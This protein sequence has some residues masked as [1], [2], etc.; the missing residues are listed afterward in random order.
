MAATVPRSDDSPLPV[1][2]R[3]PVDS[4]K[5]TYGRVL[6]VGG[7]RGMTGAAG[8]SGMAA[9]RAGAGLVQV[10]VAKS[11]QAI[12]AAYEP[13]YM[14][15]GLSE[16]IEGRLD[17][18]AIGELTPHL[19]HITTLACGPGLALT[20]GTEAVALSLYEKFERPAVFDADAL[21]AL[22]RHPQRLASHAGPRVLT[23]HPGEFARLTGRSIAEVQSARE[24][25]AGE[26]ARKHRVV[27]LLKG[28]RTCITD[29]ERVAINTTGN[30]GMATGGTGDVLTGVVAALLAQGLAPYD[31]ARLGA[32]LH[33]LAG[34]LAAA[35]LG[36]VSL[37]A[38]D[39]VDHLPSAFQCHAQECA[40]EL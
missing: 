8:L 24:S 15:L 7:A 21:N 17:A 33:G 18:S 39:L 22:A 26:F 16:D 35:I 27:V 40:A 19:A 5:G 4:N 37:I 28:H 38:R 34:D 25:M 6:L 1:L 9:L 23:P 13:S 10:A 3:R 30:P 14:T 36:E 12:V 2:P 29:G 11:C 20:D 31:A 32:H